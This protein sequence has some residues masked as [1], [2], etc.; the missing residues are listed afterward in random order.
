MHTRKCT[1]V[2]KY[3]N[4][5]RYDL[6]GVESL[7]LETFG[8]DTVEWTKKKLEEHFGEYAHDLRKYF[9]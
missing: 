1:N 3:L 7:L 2:H 4:D 8:A 9:N 6:E 5:D